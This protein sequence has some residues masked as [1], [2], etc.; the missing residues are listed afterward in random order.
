[1]AFS[2]NKVNENKKNRENKPNPKKRHF[3]PNLPKKQEVEMKLKENI[4]LLL[5]F[6]QDVKGLR[7]SN[8]NNKMII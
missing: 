2:T 8:I 7:V 3:A 4:I 5:N 1:M 6:F